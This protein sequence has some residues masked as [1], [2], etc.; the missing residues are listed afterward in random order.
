[1][2]KKENLDS[3]AWKSYIAAI[4][5]FGT[6]FELT[7]RLA[8]L[9]SGR[10][11]AGGRLIFTEQ[12]MKKALLGATTIVAA[13]IIG[14]ILLSGEKKAESAIVATEI[15][16]EG[17]SCQN[18][19]DK[20][21]AS[22][23]A[24]DGVKEVEVRL[25]EGKAYI[26]YNAAAVTVSAMEASISKLGYSAGKAGATVDKE[27]CGDAEASGCCAGEKPNNKT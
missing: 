25:G 16:I 11:I 10:N 7:A 24:L 13:A 17:M 19:V 21:N 15:G 5:I 22:L 27:D 8:Y 3:C 1:M 18:C 26:K 4:F 2:A 20:I 9:L 6:T 14:V 23:T 12:N